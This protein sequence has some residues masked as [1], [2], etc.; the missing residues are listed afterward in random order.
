MIDNMRG[1][2][3]TAGTSHR[4]MSAFLFK[5]WTPTTLYFVCAKSLARMTKTT[6]PTRC[7]KWISPLLLALS[8]QDFLIL[9]C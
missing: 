1:S 4:R 5:G 7:E 2:A 3:Y 6:K 8:V 9:G